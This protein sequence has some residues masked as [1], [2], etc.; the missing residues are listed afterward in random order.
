MKRI[1]ALLLGIALIAAISA[2]ATDTYSNSNA[3][4]CK[5]AVADSV[6]SDGTGVDLFGYYGALVLANVGVGAVFSDTTVSLELE[7]EESSDNSSF[8]D[9][10]D[11]HLVGYVAGTNDGCFGVIDYGDEDNMVYYAGYIG[12]KRYIR[13]VYNYVSTGTAPADI[14]PTSGAIIRMYPKY[15][16]AH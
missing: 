8:T 12:S 5:A 7:L 3:L 11:A 4:V 10:A 15:G 2:G 14:T 1:F 13:I 6:D 16:P 9:V